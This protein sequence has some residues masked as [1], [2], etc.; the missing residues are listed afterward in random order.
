M[1]FQIWSPQREGVTIKTRDPHLSFS[2]LPRG[3]SVKK[4]KRAGLCPNAT[5]RNSGLVGRPYP[6]APAKLINM[7]PILNWLQMTLMFSDRIGVAGTVCNETENYG[8]DDNWVGTS[9]HSY[10]RLKHKREQRRGERKKS[11]QGRQLPGLE[12]HCNLGLRLP[13][14]PL[15]LGVWLGGLQALPAPFPISPQGSR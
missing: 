11:R 1:L 5:R 12:T 6:A 15:Q 2:S 9:N 7:S 4:K 3:T 8:K 10:G 14:F 13:G